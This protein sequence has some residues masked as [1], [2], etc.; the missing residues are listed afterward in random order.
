MEILRHAS[1]VIN[2]LKPVIVMIVIQF[3]YAGMNI[4]YKL[5]ANDGMNLRVL[6]AYRWIFSTAF[7]APL[8]LIFDR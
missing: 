4:F 1:E 6:V 8:A 5:A 7:I 2:K 3:S